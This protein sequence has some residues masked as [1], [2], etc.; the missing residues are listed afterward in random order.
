MS[1]NNKAVYPKLSHNT[2]TDILI[3]GGGITGMI[4]AYTLMQAGHRVAVAEKGAIGSGYT[5][6]IMGEAN[7]AD[8]VYRLSGPGACRLYKKRIDAVTKLSR[9]SDDVK[10][11]AFS[12]RQTLYFTDRD[13]HTDQILRL[14]GLCSCEDHTVRLLDNPDTFKDFCFDME[15]GIYSQLGG[16]ADCTELA[17]RLADFID[18]NGGEIW[19]NTELQQVNASKNGRI[20]A[21]TDSKA[22]IDAK[23]MI[24][25]SGSYE[26]R[27][28]C[29]KVSFFN[30]ECEQMPEIEQKDFNCNL[31][32]DYRFTFRAC[33]RRR[34]VLASLRIP[35]MLARVKSYGKYNLRR[36]ESMLNAMFDT[37][38]PIKIRDTHVYTVYEPFG[39]IPCILQDKTAGYTLCNT[40]SSPLINA[41]VLAEDVLRLINRNADVTFPLKYA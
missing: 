22:F 4:T 39:G 19:E 41:V 3:K 40:A 23:Y 8:S 21:Q 18:I 31:T 36:V 13:D 12:H 26:D 38:T 20:T 33:T 37:D 15:Y 28:S 10:G 29:K 5:G 16:V 14:Y 2:D 34:S 7:P 27:I 30:A 35:P 11:S 25:C 17:R 32:D 9:I 1:K 6:L 24:D